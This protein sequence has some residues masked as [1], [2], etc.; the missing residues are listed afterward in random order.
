MTDPLEPI[1]YP[2]QFAERVAEA[3]AQLN[4]DCPPLPSTTCLTVLLN[5]LFQAG[6]LYEEGEPVRCRV[7]LADPTDWNRGEGPPAGFHVLHFTEPRPF[8]AQEIRKLAPAASYFRSMLGVH[9]SPAHGAAIWGLVE[10]GARWVNRA[11]GGRFQGVPLPYRFVVHVLGP[12]KLLT[13]CGYHR[14]LEL[15]AGRILLTGFDPF[16][17]NWIPAHFRPFRT[18]LLERL[19]AVFPNGAPVDERFLKLMAQNVVRRAVSLVRGRGHGGMLIY[20]PLRLKGAPEL[21]RILRIRCEFGAESSTDRFT[22]LMLQA[23]QRLSL[24]GQRHG[25]KRV[26]WEHY[27]EFEDAELA[28]IDESFFEMAHLF[29]DLMGVDGALVLTERFELVGFGAE[30]LGETP[31][32]TVHRALDLEAVAVRP[33]PADGS[34]TRHRA[35]YRLVESVPDALALVISQDGAVRFVAHRDDRVTYWP[36]LP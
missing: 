6:C 17:S 31:V 9:Y 14:L 24:L 7:I 35:A 12:G 5:T 28:E 22:E 10:S 3:W 20:L 2:P 23:M 16:R 25:L 4:F 29:A 19:A 8:T 30:V 33:E 1:V 32:K 34:G 27:Q 36:Y 18:W 21:S 26:S 15:D 13:A 11:D